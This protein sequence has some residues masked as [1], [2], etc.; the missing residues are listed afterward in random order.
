LRASI[1]NQSKFFVMDGARALGG[2]RA[3]PNGNPGASADRIV[4][5]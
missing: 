2:S 4:P 5:D 1:S 3:S